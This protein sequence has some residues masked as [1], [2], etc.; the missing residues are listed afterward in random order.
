VKGDNII[1]CIIRLI[2]KEQREFEVDAGEREKMYKC[3]SEK[4]Q[5][6]NQNKT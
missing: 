6:R 1:K 3:I 5:I 2:F 4:L